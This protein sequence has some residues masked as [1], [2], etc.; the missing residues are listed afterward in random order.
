MKLTFQAFL[1]KSK[2]TS[3]SQSLAD[4]SI[5]PSK[6]I[7][8][9]LGIL[10]TID[11]LLRTYVNL[12]VSTG[13]IALWLIPKHIFLGKIHH[14]ASTLPTD[15]GIYFIPNMVVGLVLLAAFIG[16]VIFQDR[17]KLTPLERKNGAL[18]LPIVF[19]A[20]TGFLGNF[21]ESLF[22]GYITDY[23][24]I[25]IFKNAG[26]II[27]LSDFYLMSALGL[28]PLL[29]IFILCVKLRTAS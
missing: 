13:E 24:G 28:L 7:W 22:T 16:M 8:V 9:G 2:A 27:N 10:L 17:Y 1:S 20:T 15:I 21:V 19:L 25:A 18:I 11:I 26:Q 5:W 29:L 14:I 4:I 23:L 12:F 3:D 6:R